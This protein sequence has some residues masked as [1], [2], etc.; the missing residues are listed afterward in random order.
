MVLFL[1]LLVVIGTTTSFVPGLA[2]ALNRIT[3]LSAL[4]KQNTATYNGPGQISAGVRNWIQPLHAIETSE[5]E[6]DMNADIEYTISMPDKSDFSLFYR[7]IVS[8]GTEMTLQQFVDYSS[9][10][11]LRQDG[12]IVQEDVNDLWQSAVGDA[13][14]LNEEKGYEMLCMVLDLPDPGNIKYLNQ[15]FTDIVG[16]KTTLN[17]LEFLSMTDVQDMM[18]GDT[19]TMEDVKQIW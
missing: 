2:P 15:E 1:A 6:S 3:F 16:E 19:L 14:G 10:A 9:V 18:E 11:Q 7:N 12:L 13:Q 17:F 4:D 5:T 8:E